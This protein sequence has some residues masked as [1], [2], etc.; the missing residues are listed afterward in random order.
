MFKLLIMGIPGHGHVNP[1]LPIVSELARRGATVLYYNTEEF[2]AKIEAAGAQF[3]AY[4]AV[5][6]SAERIT[7]AVERSLVDVT[8]LLFEVA[9]PLVDFMRGEIAR[10][11]PT[12]L[13]F[14]SICLWGHIAARL[15]RLPTIGS[16]TTFIQAGARIRMTWRDMA[17]M[18]GKAL[19][20][21]PRLLKLRK[22]IT[23]RYGA[24]ALPHGKIFPCT[25]DIN[26]VFTAR[27][28][29]PDTPLIDETFRFVGPS[30]S[31]RY[32]DA[33]LDL[34]AARPLVYISLGT[35]HHDAAFY[36][37]CFEAFADYPGTFVLS[38]GSQAEA[39]T[40]PE[41][42]VVRAHV[43]QLEVL[44]QADLFITHAGMNSV[45][46]A[47]YYGVPMVCVPQQIEQVLNARIVESRGAGVVL[48]DRP[49]YGKNV[50]PN[51]LRDAAD[52]V[53]GDGQYRDAAKRLQTALHTTGGTMQAVEEIWPFMGAALD[54]L[55]VLEWLPLWV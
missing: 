34:P 6:L 47:L 16:V 44:K 42:F 54:N 53:L 48:A 27:D 12:V 15:S 9:P 13:M 37:A 52:R 22:A 5:G 51:L 39:L 36:H 19:P 25:G 29:Q 24:D 23:A 26:L 30:L 14:D 55:D 7:Q 49:P 46:E 21:L 11:Q 18:L 10:E 41:N 17:H 50:T 1:T 33:P 31:P 20:K 32:N 28:L 4:P 43:P 3:R 2:R 38:A 8:E 35:I 45:Q 40:P